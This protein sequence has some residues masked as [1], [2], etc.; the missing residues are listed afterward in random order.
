M[1]PES[2]PIEILGKRR[3]RGRKKEARRKKEVRHG[4]E[5]A[6]IGRR[7]AHTPDSQH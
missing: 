4:G 7:R 3:R 1:E 2:G 6:T 5:D